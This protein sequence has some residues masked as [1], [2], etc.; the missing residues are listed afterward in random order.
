LQ[1][2]LRLGSSRVNLW[3]RACAIDALSRLAPDGVPDELVANLF[4][5]H[6]LVREMAALGIYRIDPQ[7][8]KRHLPKLNDEER[9]PLDE[10]IR[11]GREGPHQYLLSF[12]KVLLLRGLPLF[13]PIPEVILA[14][15]ASDVKEI[16]RASGETIFRKGDLGREMYVVVEGVV[17][18]DKDHRPIAELGKSDLLGEIAIVETGVRTATATATTPTRLLRVDQS[19]LYDLMAD[20]PEVMPVIVEVVS[21]R[22]ADSTSSISDAVDASE[23]SGLFTTIG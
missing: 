3:L 5:S 8:L 23:L 12:E 21:E 19:L 6:P 7:E 9:V 16:R 17:K 14:R 13:A 2:I 22:S 1:E 15:F 11:F 20:Y 10:I 18:I 4:S